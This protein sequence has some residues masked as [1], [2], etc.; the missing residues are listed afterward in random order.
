MSFAKI[1]VS[2]SPQRPDETLDA[3]VTF[4]TQT[5]KGR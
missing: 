4:T 3:P 1:T 2:Y 5:S